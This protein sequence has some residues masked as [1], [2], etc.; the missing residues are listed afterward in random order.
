MHIPGEDLE[1]W[2]TFTPGRATIA[3]EMETKEATFHL[4]LKE[5][6]RYQMTVQLGSLLTQED[7]FVLGV[8]VHSNIP[9]VDE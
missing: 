4:T 3:K 2:N 8:L 7:K 5:E 6:A 1:L 9:S